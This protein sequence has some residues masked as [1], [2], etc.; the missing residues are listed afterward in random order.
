MPNSGELAALG[1]PESDDPEERALER[2]RCEGPEVP[3]EGLT[4][5]GGEA[6]E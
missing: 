2:I 6:N 4:S 1:R 3:R 5:W